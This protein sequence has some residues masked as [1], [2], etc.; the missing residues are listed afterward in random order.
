MS[1]VLALVNRMSPEFKNALPKSFDH[2]RFTRICLTAIRK[3]PKL[4]RCD[5]QSLL[6]SLMVFAQLGLEP[7]TPLGHAYLVPFKNEVTPIIGYKGLIDLAYR[8]GNYEVI[9]AHPVY[10]GDSFDWEYG[11]DEK[12]YHKPSGRREGDPTHFYAFYKLKNNGRRFRVWSLEECLEHGKKFSKSFNNGP[13]K[14]DRNAMCMK[15]VIKDLLSFAPMSP[16]DK[17]MWQTVQADGAAPKYIEGKT[18]EI[19]YTDIKEIEKDNH[20]ASENEIEMD[21]VM[22]EMNL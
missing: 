12:L 21:N 7:N 14:S 3:N 6:G 8:T 16:E 9:D 5:P 4:Q 11:F 19:D 22:K 18:L 15:T 2:D 20:A 10:A 13:W 17:Q 1:D